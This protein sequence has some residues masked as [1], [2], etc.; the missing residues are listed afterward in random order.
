MATSLRLI[1]APRPGQIGPWML[2]PVE[3]L[4]RPAPV[5][6]PAERSLDLDAGYQDRALVLSDGEL[7]E[8]HR[9][10]RH[11]A[12]EGV[13]AQDGWRERLIPK[14]ADLETL[15]LSPK[16]PRFFVAHWYE[17]ESGFG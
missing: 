11:R 2:D 17:W 12:F 3:W 6:E 10:D 8:W 7:I 4:G 14:V 1:A 5:S 13:Y 9:R 16:C 15:L